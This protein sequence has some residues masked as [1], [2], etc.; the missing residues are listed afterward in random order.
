M[1][2]RK[3]AGNTPLTESQ[4]RA[5]ASWWS[6]GYLRLK[7]PQEGGEPLHGVKVPRALKSEAAV[8]YFW[9]EVKCLEDQ[10]S[11]VNPEAPDW[12]G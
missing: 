2:Q 10:R 7:P 8:I 9:E 1:A 12:V 3:R 11:S 4:A 6:V 5:L